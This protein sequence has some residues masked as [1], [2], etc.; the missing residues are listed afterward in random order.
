MPDDALERGRDS[1][2]RRG[3]RLGLLPE[4]RAH[5]VGGRLA[6]KRP[7]PRHQLVQNRAEAE[8]IAAGVHGL[9]AYLFGRHVADGPE[10]HA[11]ARAGRHRLAI[12]Y[13]AALSARSFG[14]AE[15]ES[16]HAAIAR[17]EQVLPLKV[18][19]A[20]PFVVRG[21]KAIG[22]LNVVLDGL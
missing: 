4:D 17:H 7:T 10:H 13:R 20:D 15:I 6:M 11:R 22:D 8:E 14:E 16:L 9:R 18:A 2:G 3:E 12:L 19:M 21:G 1:D 5:R